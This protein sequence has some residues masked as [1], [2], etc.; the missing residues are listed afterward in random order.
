[1]MQL[2]SFDDLIAAGLKEPDPQLLLL[3]LLRA[4][5]DSVEENLNRDGDSEGSGTL[6]PVMATDLA[7]TGEVRLESIVEEA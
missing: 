1:M 5:P 4:V 6:M 2:N 7:L 3:V